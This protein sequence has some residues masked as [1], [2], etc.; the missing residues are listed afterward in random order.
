[1]ASL[2]EIQTLAIELTVS[3]RTKLASNLLHSLPPEFDEDDEGDAEPLRR[4]AET[5]EGPSANLTFDEFTR[6][7]GR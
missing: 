4:D 5:D 3:K 7:V 2:A 6:V 1:M